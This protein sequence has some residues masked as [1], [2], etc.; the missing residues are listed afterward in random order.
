MF[1]GKEYV[2]HGMELGHGFGGQLG[3]RASGKIERRT[4]ERARRI[5]KEVIEARYDG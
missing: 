2:I 5:Y 4:G 1:G 3:R